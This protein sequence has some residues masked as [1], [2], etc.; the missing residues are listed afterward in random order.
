M[1]QTGIFSEGINIL[2]PEFSAV[3]VEQFLL[4]PEPKFFQND[5]N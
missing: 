4:I 2:G 5:E 3:L 1:K